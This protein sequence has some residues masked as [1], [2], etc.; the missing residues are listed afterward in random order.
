MSCRSDVG[1]HHDGDAPHDAVHGL[2]CGSLGPVLES[3][4]S[5][6]NEV[7]CW[8]VALLRGAGV[9]AGSV[10]IQ[11]S[12]TCGNFG[13]GFDTF[14]LALA[15]LGDRIELAVASE[16]RIAMDG[17]G[18]DSLPTQWSANVAGAALDHL[19]RASGLDECYEV[20]IAKGQPGGSGLG[21]SASSAGGAALAFH[22]LHPELGL[23][24]Q[25]LVEAAAAGEAVAAGRHFDDVSAVV[26]GGVALVRVR[27]GR[28]ML[29][30]VQP[31]EDLHMAVVAPELALPTREMRALLPAS[32]PMADAVTNIGNAAALVAACHAG[33]VAA[34]GACLEDR[35][36]TPYRKVRLPYFEDARAAAVAAGAFGAAVSG[37]GPSMIAACDS[38]DAAKTVA[39][40]MAA[41]VR[42]HDIPAR[43]LTAR[44]E[45]QEVHHA[46]ALPSL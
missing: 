34:L 39:H 46:V 5:S 11:A 16:D 3:R 23:S 22:A 33:D 13:P 7:G 25:A 27:A 9:S 43:A 8:H 40:A 18:A 19:R 35:L 10:V 28:P 24:A 45:Y 14:S 31:P 26:L 20:R 41:A 21:S 30:R 29:L 17:P 36:S 42:E 15:G 12:A 2:G 32:V 6:G 4:W 37:S 1:H 44:P 38:A